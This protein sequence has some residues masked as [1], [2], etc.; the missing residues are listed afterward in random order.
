MSSKE[1]LSCRRGQIN[2]QGQWRRQKRHHFAP[3]R[4]HTLSIAHCHNCVKY[5]ILSNAIDFFIELVFFRGSCRPASISI[6]I[7]AICSLKSF[8]LCPLSGA[9]CCL[10][11]SLSP[12][13]RQAQA[14]FRSAQAVSQLILVMS[15][16]TA[17]WKTHPQMQSRNQ[18][19][20][21]PTNSRSIPS[22]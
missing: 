21:S 10:L 6:V 11:A 9:R 1:T 19:H 15:C 14:F 17:A 16:P 8:F 20:R 18:K 12:H 13:F 5:G 2:S 3:I 7:R 4:R 22:H